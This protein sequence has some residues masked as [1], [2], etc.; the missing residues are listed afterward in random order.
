MI[1]EEEG[2][3]LLDIKGV[4]LRMKLGNSTRKIALDG[5]PKIWFI[6]ILG[7]LIMGVNAPLFAQTDTVDIKL[8]DIEVNFL[9]SY[10]DQDGSHSPVTGGIGTEKLSNIAPSI[11][12]NIPVDSLKSWNIDGGVDFYSSA[13]SDNINNPYLDEQH[14]SG[15]SAHDSRSYVTVSHKKKNKKKL[16]ELGYSFGTSFEWDVFSYSGGGSIT[17]NSKDHNRS[18]S[19]KSKYFFDDW[20]L[21]YPVELRNATNSFLTTDKRHSVNSSVLYTANLTKRLNGSIAADFVWQGGILSTPFHRVY[22]QGEDLPG[23]ERLPSTRYKMPVGVRLNYHLTSGI[24]LRS[25]YRHY[26]DSWGLTGNTVELTVP[27]KLHQTFRVYPFYR[28][29]QQRGVRYFA[30]YGVHLSNQD[31]YTSDFDL[32]SFTSH[33]YG[34]GFSYTPLFGIARFKYGKAEKKIAQV[35]SIKLRVA[36]YERSDGLRAGVVTLGAQVNLKR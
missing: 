32:S 15:A 21:I 34:I 6:G 25:F 18:F 4:N 33:K 20:K 35:K 2:M 26:Q 3:E 24:I 8:E 17:L 11:N 1:K 9:M 12:I 29:N 14:V 5:M 36:R 27:I 23:V 10:Y 13:S 22:F 16:V 31:F 7:V 28:Y 30:G 19:L